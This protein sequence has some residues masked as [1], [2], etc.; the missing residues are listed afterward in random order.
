MSARTRIIII[1]IGVV[2]NLIIILNNCRQKYICAYA[3]IQCFSFSYI[4][5]LFSFGAEPVCRALGCRPRGGMTAKK[6][7]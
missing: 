5:I 2:I 7:E 3:F 4:F 1:I 6:Y